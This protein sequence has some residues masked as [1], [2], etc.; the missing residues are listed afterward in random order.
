MN[1]TLGTTALFSLVSTKPTL[2]VM[3][4]MAKVNQDGSA[5]GSVKTP[6]QIYF[7]P[8]P[9]LRNTISTAPHDFRD[10]L[11]EIPAGTKVYDVY[12]TDMQ[13]RKSIWPW[14]T[15][16]YAR[17]RRNSAVKIGELVTQSEFTLS[18][19]GDTGIFFK[20]QR[21]EDR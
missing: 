9:T 21:Y 19:F 17:E 13:I 16:R 6:T 5:A 1:E 3:S 20:H 12:G 7:V 11:T 14:V 8:N 15:A 18:Q 10:D 4:D 2:L